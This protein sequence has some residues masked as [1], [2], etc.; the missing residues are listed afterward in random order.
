ML[1]YL[2]HSSVDVKGT[3]LNHKMQADKAGIFIIDCHN[4]MFI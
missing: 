4:S 1:S 3:P 2:D